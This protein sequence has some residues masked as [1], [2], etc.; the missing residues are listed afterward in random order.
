[1]QGSGTGLEFILLNLV[2]E[3]ERER[4]RVSYRI[5]CRDKRKSAMDFDTDNWRELLKLL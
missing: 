4:D 5:H 1:M 3:R 2:T